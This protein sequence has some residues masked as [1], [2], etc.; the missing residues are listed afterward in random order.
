LP[1]KGD[2]AL[3]E[4]SLAPRPSP[5]LKI[6]GLFQDVHSK[7]STPNR[8]VDTLATLGSK[9]TFEGAHTEVTLMIEERISDHRPA[10]RRNRLPATVKSQSIG[11]NGDN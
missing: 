6:G 10:S 1:S 3:K 5:C 2:F 7:T 4:A 11:L 8:Y 9:I